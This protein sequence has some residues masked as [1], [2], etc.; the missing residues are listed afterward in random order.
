[1]DMGEHGQFLYPVGIPRTFCGK[2]REGRSCPSLEIAGTGGMQVLH[3]AGDAESVLDRGPVAAPT[4]A[5][6]GCKP[7]EMVDR[8]T[9]A[10]P[11]EEGD[12]DYYYSRA[13]AVV[14]TPE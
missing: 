8:S 12:V 4:D 11:R 6:I 1:M 2:N 3:V 7:R 14:E 10:K 9:P 5:N 13:M